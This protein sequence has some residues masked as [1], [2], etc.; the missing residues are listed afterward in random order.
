MGELV[1]CYRKVLLYEADYDWAQPG[2]RRVVC[3][4]RSL[5][6]LAPGICMDLNDPRFVAHLIADRVDVCAFCTN[7]VEEGIDVHPYWQERLRDWTGWF[8][9]ANTWGEDQGTQFSGRSAILAPGGRVAA[10]APAEGDAV[11]VVDTLAEPSQP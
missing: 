11:L 1:S 5:G 8:V 7:W 6:R 3:T 9:A 2:R 10:S 4:T